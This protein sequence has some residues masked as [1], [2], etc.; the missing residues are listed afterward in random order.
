MDVHRENTEVRLVGFHPLVKTISLLA[1]YSKL[2]TLNI[3]YIFIVFE[4]KVIGAVVISNGL[5]VSPFVQLLIVYQ[6]FTGME[7]VSFV[8]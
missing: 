1:D 8:F 6:P 5:L 3:I 4:E 2:L 7:V